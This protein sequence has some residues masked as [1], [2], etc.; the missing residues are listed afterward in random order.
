MTFLQDNGFDAQVTDAEAILKA[1]REEMARGL[2]GEGRLPM[3][4]A[5]FALPEQSPR[6]CEVAAF[7]VGGTNTRSARVRF[8]AAGE[9]TI[10]NQLRGFMPGSRGLVSQE[11]FYR[12][13]CDVLEPNVRAGERLGFCFSYPVD[14]TGKLLYWTKQIQA[15][16]IVGRCVPDDL[17]AALA[18]RGTAGVSARVLNDTVAALLA[19]Y[20]HAG[21]ERAA[22]VG[23]ILGTG[24]N[25]A[26]AETGGRILKEDDLE[27][28]R[29]YPINCESGNFTNFRLSRFDER[30]EAASGNGRAIWERCIS[31]VHLG[32]LGTEILH[33]AAE[34]NLF[35]AGV[36]DGL[37][38]RTF[39]NIELD[40]FCSGKSP[41]LI[42]CS[43]AEAETIRALICPMYARAARFAAINM[44][45]AALQSA[46][47]RGKRSGLCRINADGSTFW[48]TASIPFREIVEQQLGA[49]LTPRG[50]TFEIVRIADAP[51]LGAALAIC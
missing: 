8:N 40:D 38:A 13:L 10:E 49:L 30:H 47:A 16:G 42:Y 35:S 21:E 14:G 31:G 43:A 18:T 7:D 6:S 3:L 1:F 45:A 37:L 15:P 26:Y 27:P 22:Y 33:A 11:A 12:I 32:G 28:G 51:L 29:F 9:A 36:C 20:A 23:F 2:L 50:F 46:E 41:E 5:G 48:K 24:T 17:Q 39:T 25:T 34:A 4:P 44:A 19:A